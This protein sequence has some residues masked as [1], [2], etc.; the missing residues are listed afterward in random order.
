MKEKCHVPEHIN[1]DCIV[2]ILLTM[3]GGV[4]DYRRVHKEQD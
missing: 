3:I 4:Y 1:K 2:I